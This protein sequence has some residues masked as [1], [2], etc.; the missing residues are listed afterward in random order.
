MDA[1]ER[2]SV[3]FEKSGV[4]VGFEVEFHVY[5]DCESTLVIEAPFAEVPT[6]YAPRQR[7]YTTDSDTLPLR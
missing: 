7:I 1:K 4:F 2:A 3:L 6:R 5:V